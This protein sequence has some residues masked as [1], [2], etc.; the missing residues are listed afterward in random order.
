[1]SRLHRARRAVAAH[2]DAAHPV[3]AAELRAV[4]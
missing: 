2:V 3:E 4:A 1:M